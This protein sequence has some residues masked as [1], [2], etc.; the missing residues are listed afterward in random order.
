MTR[1][2]VRL[3]EI[4][5][6]ERSLVEAIIAFQRAINQPSPTAPGSR[7]APTVAAGGRARPASG[8][9]TASHPVR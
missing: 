1:R 5:G 3:A 2:V 6:D 9:T 8:S 7:P 4:E